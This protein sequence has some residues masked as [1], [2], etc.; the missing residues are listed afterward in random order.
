MITGGCYVTVKRVTATLCPIAT[1]SL[2]HLE[3]RWSQRW[4]EE[5][6][7]AF[8]RSASRD[9]V[10]SIDTPPPTASGSLHVGHVF[11]YT[12]TDI[13]ARFQRMRGKAV[14][15][16]MGW[17]DNGLPTERRVENYYGVRC[18]PLAPYQP[19]FQPPAQ[20]AE[21]RADYAPI[22]RRNF[23]ELCH[24]LTAVD[25]QAFRR[26]F[27]HLGLSVDWGLTYATIDER[28]QR[29]SQR[30]LL[31]NYQRGELYSQQAPCLWDVTFQTA[32]AQAELEDR[33]LPGAYHDLRFQGIEGPD[34]SIATTRP[35]LLAACV[36]LV[37]HPD[38]PR[39]QGR[40]GQHLRS[41]LFE[42]EVPLLAHALADPQKGS[43]LAMVCTFGDLTDVLWWRELQLP[44]RSII[45]ADGR[46]LAQVPD[47]LATPAARQAYATLAGRSLPQ[48]RKTLL[49]LLREC[50][51][52]LGEP[53]PIRHAV[54]F[55]E[56]GDQPLE[57]VATRQWYLR[58]G[59]RSAELRQQLLGRGQALEWHPPFMRSR[60]EHWV[61]G[62]NGDW[63]ISRQRVF[64]VP[65]P[66]WYPL[67]AQGE[68][69][70]DRPIL[71]D[72][73]ALPVDP[74]LDPPPGYRPEQRGQ[75]H[76]FIGERDIMDT[77]AT[78][79]LTPQIAAG[80]EEDD[81][82][83]A[84][85][86]PMD[87]RPQGH[88]IIRTWLFSTLVRSHFEAAA[89]PWKHVAL[90]GWILDPD[91]KKMSKSRGNVVTPQG[92]LE[93]YGSDAVRYW[94]ALGR[95]G[96]D[97]AFEEQQM[98][99]GR[100]L[101]LKLFNLS[102][103]VFG[104]PGDPHGPVEQPLDQAMLQRLGAVTAA[105]EA[106]L[107]GYDYSSALI[108]IE[109]FFWWFCDDYVE[110]VKRRAYRPEGHSARNALAA[111][112]STLQRVFAPFL[113]FV[114]EEVWRCWQPG[115]VHRATWPEARAAEDFVE[116]LLEAV[117]ATL[118]A[119][120]KAKSDARQSMKAA[121]ARVELVERGP[122]LESLQCARQD[123]IEAGQV[124]NLVFIEGAAREVRV[125]LQ[126]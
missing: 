73:A 59:G 64:G 72:E 99:I 112:L 26:L 117:S 74:T 75:P 32:V 103:L 113:P 33:E 45:G 46:L 42:V 14:F 63:L 68:A 13:I 38:D 49:A 53:R 50:G 5:G 94:A 116:P 98:K 76:G 120:R 1:P 88:D 28:A 51:A 40:F 107:E 6:T 17:D 83:F 100:R 84:R 69:D 47:W 58:N 124:A 77:W 4:L 92:L 82:L 7:Y 81:D 24:Q 2:E 34:L 44:T 52:L 65:I 123:L 111:A 11:S 121:V 80:W 22:S 62:L 3:T 55:F 60:Y 106:A 93:Q 43:G 115:S 9:A 18:E 114:C 48:A 91:R 89:V 79:S 105:A 104:V 39:Y 41:P 126:G 37:A 119:I 15:Y 87:L 10:Y 122:L 96:S 54:K 97:T 36:A 85:I 8:D 108:G 109:G 35:E 16:P 20:V 125:W 30:A 29:V 102:K 118:A 25:E 21:R 90:S 70:Y 19:Q 101:A 110:L 56:K 12:H 31:R 78:S 66:F 67:D 86:Y 61:G 27:M 57:I 23:V 71:A 95:P